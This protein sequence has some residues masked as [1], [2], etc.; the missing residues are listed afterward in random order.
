MRPFA[1]WIGWL[2]AF[3]VL[4]LLMAVV[5]L[6][7]AAT[8]V[9]MAGALGVLWPAGPAP[10][11]AVQ[12]QQWLFGVYGAMAVP[13]A[14]FGLLI[15]RRGLAQRA[16]WAWRAMVAASV[17]WY[18]ADT[19]FSVTFGM[20]INAWGNTVLVFLWLI[21]LLGLRKHME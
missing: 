4:Y 14:L 12:L 3:F 15:V 1:L 17:F 9:D 16:R 6:V 21:P 13:C 5:V 10:E 18:V 19:A 7:G 11:P 8:G 20:M 2:T